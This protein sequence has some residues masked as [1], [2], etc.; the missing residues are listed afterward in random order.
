[1]S[2]C[3]L[4]SAEADRRE[5]D[6]LQRRHMRKQVE[7][8]ENKPDAA[9]DPI[10]FLAAHPGMNILTVE[11]QR[12]RLNL[13]QAIDRA[14]QGRLARSRRPAYDDDLALADLRIDVDQGVVFTVSL[15]D[16][17]EFDHVR[18]SR[19]AVSN[20]FI[21]PPA[22]VGRPAPPSSFRVHLRCQ[23]A[24]QRYGARASLRAA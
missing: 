6:V 14:D 24:S 9:S 4:E 7:A 16:V 20:M 22:G 1:M 5:H 23:R 8:L 11:R 21:A 10:D 18:F 13:L 19:T 17:R 15:V 3:G 2:V 12:S